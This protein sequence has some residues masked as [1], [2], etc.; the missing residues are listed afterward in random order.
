MSIPGTDWTIET[1]VNQMKKNNIMLNPDFQRRDAW[2]PKTKS[3]FIESIFLGLPIPQIILAEQ[4]GKKGKF[5]VI[6][7][8]QRLLALQQFV[9]GK[10]DDDID[11]LKLTGLKIKKDFNRLTYND[12]KSGRFRGEIDEFDNQTI[13]TIVVKN[14]PALSVL[15]LLFERLNTGSISLSPQELRQA[16]FPGDFIRYANNKSATN[17]ELQRML[18]LSKPDFRM[19][20][21]EVFIRYFAF[22][23][24][25]VLYTGSMQKFLDDT[26]DK[27]NS[28]WE[29]RQNQ[30]EIDTLELSNAIN[31]VIDT[32]GIDNAFKKYKNGK[33]EE[34]FNRSV[35]DIM[36]YY[37]SQPD[38][39]NSLN[40][41]KSEIQLY[42]QELC[43]SDRDFLSSIEFTTKSIGAV[44]K[45]FQSWGK[46]LNR[47][48]PISI[49]VIDK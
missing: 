15:Y 37:F 38:I 12:I 21:V 13:R 43:S 49:P 46:E 34:K 11:E 28:E 31:F 24:F 45:R 10:K 5:F 9:L 26:C 27:L 14:W 42:F 40:D 19:R 47:L 18:K 44:N 32:F 29:L 23:Y 33:Y 7:G 36:L 20:D 48:V 39:R 17:I 4:K 6:D 41:K 8:K 3:R 1:I 22:K 25:F 16:V 35:I 2:T 30:I